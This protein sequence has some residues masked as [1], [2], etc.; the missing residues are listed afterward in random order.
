[1]SVLPSIFL[2]V[3]QVIVWLLNLWKR[4]LAFEV[5]I[6]AHHR[7][8][9]MELLRWFF[10]RI[11]FMERLGV[12]LYEVLQVFADQGSTIVFV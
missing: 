7:K 12:L 3:I 1:M 5:W 2:F 10:W 6:V 9:K 8:L 4:R 11:Q